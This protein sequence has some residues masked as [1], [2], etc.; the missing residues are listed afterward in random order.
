MS[1][2]Y[3]NAIVDTA[4]IANYQMSSNLIDMRSSVNIIFNFVFNKLKLANSKFDPI[5][6]PLY[7]F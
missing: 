3:N 4:F 2:P 5:K 7:D 6:E 1:N